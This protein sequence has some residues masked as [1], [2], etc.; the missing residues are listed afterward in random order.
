MPS[1]LTAERWKSLEPLIDAAVDLPRERW[2][3]FLDDTCSDDAALRLEVERLL[4]EYDRTDTLLDHPAAQRFGSLLGVVAAPPPELVNGNYRIER[5]LGQGGMATVYLAHDIRHDR[6]V[7]VKLLHPE[8]SA[9]FRTEQF[10]AEIRT[11]AG[12]SHP[13]ILPLHD[14]GEAEGLLFFVMPYVEGETLR[15]RIDRDTQLDIE[16]VVRITREV[17]GALDSAHRHGVIHRDIKPENILLGEGG[18]LVADFGIALAVSTAS[19]R[20]A[21]QP[22]WIAGTPRYMSP[23]QMLGEA[24]IDNRSDVYSLGVVAYE[25][26]TGQPPRVRPTAPPLHGLRGGIPAGADAVLVNALAQAPGDRYST[27]GAFA[28][29]LHRSLVVRG[30]RRSAVL[31]ATGIIALTAAVIGTA[32]VRRQ[33]ATSAA[34]RA[35]TSA[36]PH[37]PH[38][39]RNLAAYDLYQR[40]RDQ[41]FARSDSGQ[42]VAIEYYK[43][44]IA[45]DPMYAAAYAGLAHMYAIQGEVADAEAAALKA[46]SLDDSLA[47]AHAE[48]GYVLMTAKYNMISAGAEL[49][50]AL[51]LDPTSSRPH[52]YL[53]Y[54]YC[55]IERPADAL[56]EARR[57]TELDPLSVENSAALAGALY[58]AGHY[59]EALALIA[60]LREV[61]PPLARLPG[62]AAGIYMGRG[63]WREAIAELGGKDAAQPDGL[64]GRALAQAG[65]RTDA[66][67]VLAKLMRSIRRGEGA[68]E[69]DVAMV[70]E[71]LGDY[72]NAFA[73][74]DKAID[75]DTFGVFIMA[76]MFAHLRADPRFERIRQRLNR[77]GV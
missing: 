8:L 40:A 20:D 31:V 30:T 59:D 67:R 44:A 53:I 39:T 63:M 66:R 24:S 4:Q 3:A 28:D 48:L 35:L 6:K 16:D 22:G 77:G 5:K 76:P 69:F 15:Q 61:R 56:A 47:D 51:A 58:F 26:L 27:A 54:Y 29:A 33:G 55:W 19:A 52:D 9:A 23:E 12:L 1:P 70:Y 36:T 41:L 75:E 68:T 18:A 2:P 60:K 73:R 74:L 71:G 43:Q 45:A 50:R 21:S 72:D 17:A 37:D 46:V 32:L 64:L 62:L 14:S 57:A 10:L 11:M 13:H 49:H 7:A 65:Y 34:A 42:R 25:M 38:Q